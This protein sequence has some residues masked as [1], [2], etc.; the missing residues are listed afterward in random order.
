MSDPY[1]HRKHR[2]KNSATLSNNKI[3]HKEVTNDIATTY[4]IPKESKIVKT[5]PR[6][7]KVKIIKRGTRA[8]YYG[9]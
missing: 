1:S 2:I 5:S 4:D 3:E 9:K 7:K 8:R 6:N